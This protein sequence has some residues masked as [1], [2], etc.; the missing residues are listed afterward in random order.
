MIRYRSTCNSKQNN[1]IDP[2]CR[3]E[4]KAEYY[5]DQYVPKVH[6]NAITGDILLS[7]GMRHYFILSRPGLIPNYIQC[8]QYNKLNNIQNM[9]LSDKQD[10]SKT[11]S[12]V[13]WGLILIHIFC[14]GL[15][16]STLFWN[17]IWNFVN[18]CQNCRKAMQLLDSFKYVWFKANYLRRS[19]HSNIIVWI[20]WQLTIIASRCR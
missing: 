19:C 20:C 17:E 1:W 16:R 5:I 12:H 14:K 10:G 3:E 8:M 15:L 18:W 6:F 13:T 9:N 2:D 4:S 11:R 7:K